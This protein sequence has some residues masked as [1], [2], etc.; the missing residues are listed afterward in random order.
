MITHS[1]EFGFLTDVEMIPQV[2]L[3]GSLVQT[4][5]KI[6]QQLAGT[7][8]CYLTTNMNTGFTQ[9]F[10]AMI[11]C[12]KHKRKIVKTE[13]LLIVVTVQKIILLALL[14]R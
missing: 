11:Y 3:I 1:K 8:G 13:G 6:L 2:L 14:H 4:V 5:D 10:S 7:I 12:M 9:L